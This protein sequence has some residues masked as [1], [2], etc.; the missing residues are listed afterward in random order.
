MND[1]RKEEILD[2][3]IKLAG[4]NGIDATTMRD[5]A[6]EAGISVGLIYLEYKNKEELIDAFEARMDSRFEKTIGRIVD[7]RLPIKEKLYQLLIGIVESNSLNIRE[8]RGIFEFI[9]FDFFK[10]INKTIKDRQIKYKRLLSGRIETVLRQG[11]AEKV[12][13]IE[14]IAATAE[15]LVDALHKYLVGPAVI[16]REHEEVMRDA[17][18]MAKLL[19]RGVARPD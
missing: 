13:M 8:N 10:Y 12:F 9:S 2:A 16:D 3:F 5:I 7:R 14:D 6:R 17:K 11:V 19:I 18:A 1:N 15:L 4:R